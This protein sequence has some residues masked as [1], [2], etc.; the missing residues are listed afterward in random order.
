MKKRIQLAFAFFITFFIL[1]CSNGQEIQNDFMFEAYKEGD[2]IV[3]NSVNGGS[4]TLV[5]TDKGFEVEGEKNKIVMFDFFGTFCD[6]CKEEALNLSKLWQN[7]SQKLIIIGL[8]HFEKVSDEEVKKFADDYGAYYFLSNS[9][10]ND[11]LIAQ[12]LQD[13]NYQSMEQLPFKVVLKNG[14]YQ[15]LTDYW[16]EG[17]KTNFYLGKIPTTIIQEDLDRIYKAN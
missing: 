10:Q 12:M 3:L 7:N 16:N 8:T 6:P 15:Q 5:R 17:N 14:N 4:K 1:G 9:N 13:I 2:K 11:R